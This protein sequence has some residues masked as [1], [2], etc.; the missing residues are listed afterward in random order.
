[1]NIKYFF[2]NQ[3]FSREKIVA[4]LDFTFYLKESFQITEKRDRYRKSNTFFFA[5]FEYIL[6]KTVGDRLPRLDNAELEVLGVR[7][8]ALA[9]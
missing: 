6:W 9:Q 7:A 5:Y 8:Q 1:M 3:Y 2:L 4:C